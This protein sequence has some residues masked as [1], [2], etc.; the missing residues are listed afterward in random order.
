MENR[1]FIQLE[2]VNMNRKFL[3]GI[4]IT[5]VTLLF[6]SCGNLMDSFKEPYLS[7]DFYESEPYINGVL[8]K[9][10]KDSV[11]NANSFV[12][13][14]N[15]EEVAEFE[16]EIFIPTDTKDNYTSVDGYS[17]CGKNKKGV[18]SNEEKLYLNSKGYILRT[19]YDVVLT[20]KS[21]TYDSIT[22]DWKLTLPDDLKFYNYE[23]SE[24]KCLIGENHYDKDLS[25]M[26]GKDIGNNQVV[27]SNLNTAKSY[28]PLYGCLLYSYTDLMGVEHKDIVTKLNSQKGYKGH[29]KALDKIENVSVTTKSKSAVI[30]YTK[31]TE[32]QLHGLSDYYYLVRVTNLDD[33][34]AKPETTYFKNDKATGKDTITGLTPETNYQFDIYVADSSSFEEFADMATVTG[35]TGKALAALG[36]PVITETDTDTTDLKTEITVKFDKHPDDTAEHPMEYQV[37]YYLF[38]TSYPNTANKE[39]ISYPTDGK[40]VISDLNAGNTYKVTLKAR[41]KAEPTNIISTEVKSVQTKKTEN[42][43]YLKSSVYISEKNVY[44]WGLM[45]GEGVPEKVYYKMDVSYLYDYSTPKILLINANTCSTFAFTNKTENMGHFDVYAYSPDRST[46]ISISLK[47]VSLSSYLAT[48][49]A[50]D[51]A[52]LCGNFI[53]DSY[54]YNDCIYLVPEKMYSSL[55]SEELSDSY[56]VAITFVK[57]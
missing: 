30:S 19:D 43:K 38:K 26:K 7:Y 53:L 18:S 16:D 50:E 54:V 51:V 45:S 46:K 10:K 56:K 13:Y 57:G 8:V 25:K 17:I 42:S 12:L 36:E 32:E 3:F 29:T 20:Q 41:Q 27:L 9:I 14:Y 35:K 37:E 47:N 33:A 5:A 49:T 24:L 52:N 22:F 44:N 4:L 6:V 40:I 23:K 1:K 28:S 11:E 2:E 21:E 34:N 55:Y 39:Y 31:L 48:K 15:D